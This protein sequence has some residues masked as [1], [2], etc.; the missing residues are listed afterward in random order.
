VNWY[1]EYLCGAILLKQLRQS[2]FGF[3]STDSRLGSVWAT[4]PMYSI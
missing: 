3:N 2:S 1:I 4:N